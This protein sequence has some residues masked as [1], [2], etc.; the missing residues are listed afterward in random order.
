[1]DWD[2]VLQDA[3]TQHDA[4]KREHTRKV[5]HDAA[6]QVTVD[7]I[8]PLYDGLLAGGLSRP[9]AWDVVMQVVR[10]RIFPEKTL[11]EKLPKKPGDA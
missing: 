4:V 2:K 8:L 9:E 11:W 6:K 10:T 7:G 1:M 3:A 5:I